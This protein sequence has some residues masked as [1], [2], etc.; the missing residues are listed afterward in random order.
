MNVDLVRRYRTHRLQQAIRKQEKRDAIHDPHAL[1]QAVKYVYKKGGRAHIKADKNGRAYLGSGKN[2]FGKPSTTLSTVLRW[3]AGLIDHNPN[4]HP[5]AKAAATQLLGITPAQCKKMATH[6][7][8]ELCNR[9]SNPK[10]YEET[11]TI[12]PQHPFRQDPPL[13]TEQPPAEASPVQEA[14]LQVP[15]QRTPIFTPQELEQWVNDKQRPA[16]ETHAAVRSA[17]DTY[18]DQMN[19]TESQAAGERRVQGEVAELLSYVATGNA[20]KI[21]PNSGTWE[22]MH[23]KNCLASEVFH[24]RFDAISYLFTQTDLPRQLNPR[25]LNH[26]MGLYNQMAAMEQR[27]R[28]APTAG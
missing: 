4:A 21:K 16:P 11:V 25:D 10:P 15:E 23:K 13:P 6:Q 14:P 12:P 26:L 9:M 1:T 24:N 28:T 3:H 27:S 5:I 22:I 7:L 19:S 18:V 20:N 17:V 2:W 8:F